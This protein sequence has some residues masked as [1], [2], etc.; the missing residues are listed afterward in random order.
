MVAT[1]YGPIGV[2]ALL[3]LAAMSVVKTRL[4]VLGELQSSGSLAALDTL[5]LATQKSVVYGELEAAD[6]NALFS[7]YVSEQ[8]R[9]YTNAGEQSF[10]FATFKKNL[11][12]IDHLNKVHPYALFGITKFADTTED[13]RIVRRS[14]NASWSEMKAG[15]PAD[16]L[17]A[18]EEGPSKVMELFGDAVLSDDH[19]TG[20]DG[21]TDDAIDTR[22]G[23]AR[24]K[25]G[26]ITDST[27]VACGKP[28]KK[29]QFS[30]AQ[31][32]KFR[33]YST[34]YQPREFDWRA[35][36]AV[37]SVKDTG[38]CASHWAFAA[39]GDIEGTE[40]IS[41]DNDL[42]SLSA[43]QLVA[44]DAID[45]GCMGGDTFKAFQYVESFGGIVHDSNYEYKN[46]DTTASMPHKTPICDK[47][48]LNSAMK[49]ST[50]ARVGGW[51]MVAMGSD[52]EWLLKISLLRNGPI[53]VAMNAEGMDFYV[54]GVMG[55]PSDKGE[56]Q[57]GSIDEHKHCDPTRLDMNV[58]IVGYG[59]Q[60]GLN[61]WVVK[62]SWGDVWG[63]DGYYRIVRGMNHCGIANFATHSVYKEIAMDHAGKGR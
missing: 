56:C 54:H 21:G 10:R 55:C 47:E 23:M 36:G 1:R 32:W 9:V 30:E 24:G 53:A 57:S 61:Y 11:A 48:A 6:V 58:I 5:D 8:G 34:T 18:A 46:V 12:Q 3:T 43:Q 45:H 7:K 27:C 41:T 42:T 60:D 20:F 51:Q 62:N 15:L 37:T 19:D 44:C 50:V 40:F 52:Y 31:I 22:S 4:N 35:L 29:H 17:A 39:A 38:D 49:A 13:E 2:L 16:V 33:N 25:V 14:R 63:E 59:E 28:D 26:W